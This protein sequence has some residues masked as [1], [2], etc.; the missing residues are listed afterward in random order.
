MDMTTVLKTV[1]PWLGTAM[2]GPLG[3]MALGFIADKL[4]LSEKTEEAVKAAL[5]NAD[6]EQMLLLKTADQDFA[7]KMQALGFTNVENIAKLDNEDRN[8]ARDREIKVGDNTPKI[9]AY[10]TTIGFFGVLS[11]I[12]FYDI[13]SNNEVTMNIMLGSLGTAWAG[14]MAYYYGANSGS[15]RTKELLAGATPT[16]NTK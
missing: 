3:G 1:A 5:S 15:N 16:V 12:M 8:S 7:L 14:V 11:A 2:G 9:L 4:G 10:A 6:P 13:P